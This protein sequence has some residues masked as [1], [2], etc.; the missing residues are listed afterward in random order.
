MNWTIT[1]AARALREGKLTCVALLE[2]C[3]GRIGRHEDKV[4]AWVLVD[5]PRARAEAAAR[6]RE[7]SQGCDRGL[8]HGIPVGIKDIFDVFDWPTGCGSALW[9]DAVARQDAPAVARLRQAGAV[10]V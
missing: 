3:L 2:E 7:L 4:R 10:L 5:R 1:K 6:D 8:L 9:R